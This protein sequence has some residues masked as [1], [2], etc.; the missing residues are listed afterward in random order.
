[1]SE[2]KKCPLCPDGKGRLAKFVGSKFMVVQCE[3]C[4]CST[5]ECFYGAEAWAAW[6]TRP[7]E[8]ALRAEIKYLKHEVSLMAKAILDNH[9]IVPDADAEVERLKGANEHL[10]DKSQRLYNFVIGKH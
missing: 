6:N 1:M 9:K 4:L 2:N 7:A 3:N 5:V 10:L 8:D